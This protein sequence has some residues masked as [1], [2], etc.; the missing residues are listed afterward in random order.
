[1]ARGLRLGVNA[2]KRLSRNVRRLENTS[3]NNVRNRV[4]IIHDDIRW[5][6]VKNQSA[7]DGP[8]FG[9]AA[10]VGVEEIEGEAILLIERPSTTFNRDIIILGPEGCPGT[11]SESSPTGLATY[12]PD[13]V[14]YDSGTP[15]NGD[16]WGPKPNQWSLSNGY[17]QCALC[18]GDFDST[19]KIMLA[20]LQPIE[21][22]LAKS[23]GTIANADS[24]TISI[25]AGAGAWTTDTGQDPTAVNMGPPVVADDL[26]LFDHLNGTMVF[27]KACT[28]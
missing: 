24:G 26:I 9:A 17:P 14:L 21:K 19:N 23:N 20:T 18:I 11:D 5:L 27:S 1:M 28:A 10:V 3:L 2:V 12:T 16:G 22:G 8:A 7:S 13:F 6:S 15:A 25:Y 4:G